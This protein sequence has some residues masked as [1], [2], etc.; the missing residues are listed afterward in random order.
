MC[1]ILFAHDAHPDWPL[2][3][4]ANRD[5]AYARPAAAAAFWSD[6]PL[7]C[8]G[9]DLEKGG[10]WLGISRNGRFATVT[11]YRDGIS[12]KT[13]PRSRGEL[14]AGFLRGNTKPGAYL[15]AVSEADREYNDF[16]LII[17][18]H[19]GLWF[20]S[21]RAAGATRITA[22]VHGLSNSLLD[23]P[24]PKVVRGKQELERAIQRNDCG[25]I[26]S[27]FALL[28]DRSV[29]PDHHLPDT[30]VGVERERDLSP[31]FIASQ[32]YGTRA[33]TVVLVSRSGKVVFTERRFGSGGAFKG[34][35]RHEFEIER[36][37]IEP[38]RRQ[39]R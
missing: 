39:G 36:S 19:S 28:A 11:N 33:S 10:T 17:G 27:L 38:P 16:C 18:D 22:G 20:H 1:L 9:R 21:N 7:V 35:T 2:V 34:E 25:L 30:G 3:V 31:A 6:A 4:A 29:A 12:A 24:W 26:T 15:E 8:A 13:A 32:L 37:Q 5:E 14:T 23:T